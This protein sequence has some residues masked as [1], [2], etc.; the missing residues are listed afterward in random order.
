MSD[1][2]TELARNDLGFGVSFIK[3]RHEGVYR[4]NNQPYSYERYRLEGLDGDTGIEDLATLAQVMKNLP[5]DG[6]L[7]MDEDELLEF[8]K[9][10]A[11][12]LSENAEVPFTFTDAY[13]STS[14]YTP[15]SLWEASGS[16]SEWEESAQEGYD[17][18]WDL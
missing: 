11:R 7:G 9:D 10:H 17:Y 2:V 16:C 6:A 8:L 14:T 4:W 3:D 1:T 12:E 18:G 5:A 15:A 13:G